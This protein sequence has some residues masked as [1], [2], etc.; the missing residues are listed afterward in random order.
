MGYGLGWTELRVKVL[1]W[2][3]GARFGAGVMALV[4][5]WKTR[6]YVHVYIQYVSLG[7][8]SS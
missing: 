2:V 4:E 8:G 1:G 7:V 6:T 5:E 3:C